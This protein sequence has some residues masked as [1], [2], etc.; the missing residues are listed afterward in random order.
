MYWSDYVPAVSFKS[1]ISFCKIKESERSIE[2]PF[3]T[4]IALPKAVFK[5]KRQ[6]ETAA[7]G[8]LLP[9]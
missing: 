5:I 2:S 1:G 6:A 3:T 4:N 7:S 9:E 8:A